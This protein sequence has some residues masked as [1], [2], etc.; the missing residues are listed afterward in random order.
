MLKNRFVTVRS[1]L[2]Q[3]P[4]QL[5]L[6]KERL[7]LQSISVSDYAQVKSQLASEK[8]T[9]ANSESQLSIAKINLMQLMELPVVTGFNIVHPDL[10]KSL[11]QSRI[12]DVK[13]VY[14]TAL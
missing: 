13:S 7:A 12:P 8:L 5:N 1:R 4:G 2:N 14:E 9:L 3:L 6:A 11:N 10:L